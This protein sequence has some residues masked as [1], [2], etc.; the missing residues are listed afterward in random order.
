MH[1]MFIAKTRLIQITP[2]GCLE[3]KRKS[4]HDNALK[5][6]FEIV[7]NIIYLQYAIYV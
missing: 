7:V 5:I 1:G 3:R 2:A 4:W 6:A